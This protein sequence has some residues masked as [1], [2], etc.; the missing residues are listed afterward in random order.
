MALAGEGL[1]NDSGYRSES[2][3]KGFFP[4]WAFRKRPCGKAC[5]ISRPKP[6][7]KKGSCKGLG[8][9]SLNIIDFRWSRQ[10]NEPSI[11]KP[12]KPPQTR[13]N[14]TDPRRRTDLPG[15]SDP[16][17]NAS[18]ASFRHVSFV[19][20]DFVGLL[21]RGLEFPVSGLRSSPGS[22]RRTEVRGN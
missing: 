8:F 4:P 14:G 11:F 22:D 5:E 19:F 12:P 20:A 7:Q 13:C 9:R 18:N 2:K 10:A 15:Q 3:F 1:Q 16:R 21:S 6:P 17:R